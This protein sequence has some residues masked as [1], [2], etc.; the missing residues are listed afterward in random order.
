LPKPATSW[1]SQEF[2][3]QWAREKFIGWM[4]RKHWLIRTVPLL[5]YLLTPLTA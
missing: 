2:K 5:P 1:M 4:E 3:Q